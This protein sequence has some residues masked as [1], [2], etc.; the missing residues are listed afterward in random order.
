[1]T[2]LSDQWK[3]ANAHGGHDPARRNGRPTR[4][5]RRLR[6]A[7]DGSTNNRYLE[8]WVITD[9]QPRE[10]T[11]STLTILR[12]RS[13]DLARHAPSVISAL[14]VIVD[15]VVGTGFRVNPQAV[16]ENGEPMSEVNEEVQKLW[17][18]WTAEIDLDMRESLTMLLRTAVQEYVETGEVFLVQ[19]PPVGDRR[20]RIVPVTYEVVASERV[21]HTLDRIPNAQDTTPGGNRIT[22]GI[23]YAASGQRVAYWVSLIGS[24]GEITMQHERITADRVFHLFH[25]SRAGQ[26]RGVPWIAGAAV[27]AHDLDDLI[28]TELTSAQ[29]SACLTGWIEREG[30]GAWASGQERDKDDDRPINRFAPGMLFD[31]QPGEKVNTIDPNRPSGAFEPFANFITRSI[32]RTF[33]LSF[34]AVSGDWRGVNFASGRLGGLLERKTFRR[35]QDVVIQIVLR[36]MYL[37]FYRWIVATGKLPGVSP[38]DLLLN[39]RRLTVADYGG[40]GWEHHDPLKE[41][42]AAGMRI[43]TGLSTLDDETTALGRDWKAVIAQRTRELEALEEAGIPVVSVG[44][45][46][47]VTGQGT[48]GTQPVEPIEGEGAE[49]PDGPADGSEGD[50]PDAPTSDAEPAVPA[51]AAT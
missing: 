25:R 26:E 50:P 20:E 24:F 34:E 21:D 41:V 29:V 48:D 12:Q 7:Y 45:A 16:T 10:L 11:A 15:N 1:M 35:I 38:G 2:L 51:G 39:W 33:G 6:G 9:T 23:E 13:R 46:Q 42:T 49:G 43:I 14:Q 4:D 19:R 30:A 5:K 47:A 22:A 3:K 44:G 8:D 32:A 28:D 40:A 17:K 27:M 37:T 18:A 31:L 36:P